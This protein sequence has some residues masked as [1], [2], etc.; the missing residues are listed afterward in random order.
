M[1]GI[2]DADQGLHSPEFRAP[3]RMAQLILQVAGRA[4]R[5]EQPGEVYIQTHHPDHPLLL[6]LVQSGY[7]AFARELLAER[8]E[9]GLPPYTAMAL[10]RAEAVD[11]KASL[12]FLRQLADKLEGL[13]DQN[14]QLFGP[15]PSPMEK[16]AGRYRAQ[17]V[18]S[19]ASRQALQTLL[20]KAL[21]MAETIRSNKVRWSIDVDPVDTY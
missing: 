17:L 19:A 4:G 6:S 21:P 11:R 18:V 8:E 2:V 1:V 3:E 7:P 13:A 10:F 12:E 5:A 15:L 20:A 14:V 9:T 16:R